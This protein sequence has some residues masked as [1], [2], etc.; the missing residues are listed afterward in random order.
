[1]TMLPDLREVARFRNLVADRLGLHIDESRLGNLTEVLRSRVAASGGDCSSYLDRLAD[2]HPSNQ[3]LQGL[4]QDL[5]VTETYFFR[6]ADQIT[7]FAST[8]L[9]ER[10]ASLAGTR[11]VRILSVGCAS[12]EEPYSL[13]IAAREAFPDRTD[14]VSIM[15]FDI[16]SVMLERAAQARYSIWSLRE[17]PEAQKAR[18]FTR[19]GNVFSIDPAIQRAVVFHGRNLADNDADFWRSGQFDVVFCR[20]I[21]MYFTDSQAQAAV[22]RIAHALVP[23]GYLFLGYAETLR[24]LSN[25]FHLCHTHDSFYYQRKADISTTQ[26]ARS[27]VHKLPRIEYSAPMIVGDTNWVEIIQR[28]TMRIQELVPTAPVVALAPTTAPTTPDLSRALEHMRH[29]QFDRA[30]DRLSALPPSQARDPDVLLLKAVSLAHSSALDAAQAVCQELLERDA[31]NAGAHYV[32]A[33]CREGV[34]DVVG[35]VEHNQEAA[36]L[37]PDFAMPHLH[38]GLLA[39]RQGDC[40]MAQRELQR[41]IALLQSEDAGRVLLFGG[42]FRRE[43]LIALC[44]AECT[45]SA[46]SSVKQEQRC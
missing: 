7:A 3:D 44:Q 30:L 40:D 2:P 34:G 39:K 36:Y 35:A 12:G 33:L 11:A 28:S 15:A 37:D 17:A 43:A 38:L 24:G 4:A 10:M 13:A 29:E 31:L 32:L 18:W 20:N 6:S 1:M 8:V 9:P 23:G 25:D 27:P 21:L 41:A 42:G 22:A 45:A 46:A 14:S 26:E 16:N 5:T 19:E